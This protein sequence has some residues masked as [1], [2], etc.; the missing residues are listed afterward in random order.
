[1]YERNE[2]LAVEEANRQS[3]PPA[4]NP[5]S[6]ASDK[7]S[8]RPAVSADF[9]GGMLEN[10][11]MKGPKG[12]M[13]IFLSV[14]IHGLVLAAAIL[15]PLFF[16]NALNFHPMEITYLVAP[17][18]PPAPPPPAA[19]RPLPQPRHFFSNKQLYAPRVIP[20]QAAM[21]KDIPR[22]PQTSVGVPGGIVG[23]IPGG[24]LGGVMG[25]LLGGTAHVTPPPPPKLTVHRG[26]YKVG[27]RVQPPRIIDEVQPEY[28]VIA[29]EARVQGNVLIDSVINTQGDVTQMKL[30]SGNPLLVQA[31][32]NAVREWKYQ[33]TL[34]NGTPISV[35]M[36]VTVHFSLAS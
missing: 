12:A 26:P 29:K 27:G 20:Q 34:L 7:S 14:V 31:A 15:I 36:E 5:A 8:K 10:N 16:S 19:A 32:F 28:S 11:R 1:M 2:S 21:V 24:Q 6:L 17:P 25:G 9:S 3:R 23:G 35:E 13:D 30:V 33:P 4:K 22:A 18:P